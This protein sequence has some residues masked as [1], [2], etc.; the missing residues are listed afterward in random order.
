M[1]LINSIALLIALSCVGVARAQEE[2]PSVAAEEKPPSA[3]EAETPASSAAAARTAP[4]AKAEQGTAREKE[5]TTSAKK[6]QPS[7]SPSAAP[8]IRKLSVR[9]ILK[10]N[11]NR[12][13]AAIASHDTAT[14]EALVADDFI[15]VNSKGKV[16]NRRALLHEMKSSKDTYSSARNENLDVHIFDGSVAV[17]VGTVREKG[18]GQ[19]GKAFDKT[20]RFTD[21]WMERN[22]KWQCIASQVMLVSPK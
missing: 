8:T 3:V 14:V 19:D 21:T 22:G 20:E 5:A 9:A 7:P 11:E 16:S 1:K 18:A 10:D 12:W 4:S 15:G 13:E 2:S 17:V 6:E